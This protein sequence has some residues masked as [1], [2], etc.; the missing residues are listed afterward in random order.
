M[1]KDMRKYCLLI[2]VLLKSVVGLGQGTSSPKI[3]TDIPVVIPPSPTVASLMKFEEVPVSNYSGTPN[4][5]IPLFNLVGNH[6]L[7]FNMSLDYSPSSNKKEEIAGYTGLGWSLIAGGSISRTVRDIPDDAFVTPNNFH[8][9]KIGIYH[10]DEGLTM[11]R[12]NYYEIESL[13]TPN[14]V[15][16]LEDEGINRF[17]FETNEKH[18][19]DS[20]HDLYQF[21]FMGYTGR[22]IIKKKPNGT[23][24]IEKLDKNNLIINYNHTSKTFEI[25]DTKG[26]RYLFDI[27]EISSTHS[28][29]IAYKIDGSVNEDLIGDS[30]EFISAFQLSKIFYNQEL[31]AEFSYANFEENQ[32]TN[33]QTRNVP[34]NPSLHELVTAAHGDCNGQYSSYIPNGVLP[35]HIYNTNEVD[36]A[37]KKISKI[38]IINKALIDFETQTGEREDVNLKVSNSKPY[39]KEMTVRTWDSVTIVKKYKFDYL[40]THKMFLDK[41]TEETNPSQISKHEFRYNNL[42]EDYSNFDADYWGYYRYKDYNAECVTIENINRETDKIYC[43]KDA[44]KQIVYPTKG[45][46]IFEF[47]SNTYSYISDYEILDVNEEGYFDDFTNNPDNTTITNLDTIILSNSSSQNY[48]IGN[49]IYDL[50]IFTQDRVFIFNSNFTGVDDD[51]LGFLWLKGTKV[52]NPS[53]DPISIGIHTNGCPRELKLKEGYH[54]SIRFDWSIS[55]PHIVAA[56]ISIDEKTKNAETKQWL[57]GGG[58]RVKNIYYTDNDPEELAIQS[59][60]NNYSRKIGYDYNFFTGGSR[61]SGSLVFQKPKMHYQKKAMFNHLAGSNCHIFAIPSVDY[62][63]YTTTNNLSCIST[64]GSDVGYKNVAVSETGNGKTEFEYS[65]PI[66]YPEDM[67]S[68]SVAYPFAPTPNI[69]Y[70]RGL[71]TKTK[72][73]DSNSRILNE[74][75]NH[76]VFEDYDLI[77]GFT[78]FSLFPDC[79]YAG[80]FSN[81]DYYRDGVLDSDTFATD[82]MINGMQVIQGSIL[83]WN[84]RSCGEFVSDFVSYYPLKEAFGWVKLKNSF[85]VDYFYDPNNVQSYIEKSISYE[86]NSSNMQLSSEVLPTSNNGVNIENKY[87]YTIDSECDSEPQITALRNNNMVDTP[88]KIESF[89]NGSKVSEQKVIYND[90]GDSLLL[91]H[92]IQASKGLNSLENKIN[93]NAYNDYGHPLEVQQENGMIISYLWGY[94]QSQPIAKI[95][96]ATNAQVESA[97]GMGLEAVDESNLPTNLRSLL[98]NAMI[99]TYTY[100]PLVGVSTITDPR[101]MTTTYEYDS[102]GRLKWVKDYEGNIL[103]ENEYHYRTQN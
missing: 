38:K 18:K 74:N 43:K 86:Y 44:L 47:E 50:G 68:R 26:F 24:E 89:K 31:V 66:D 100:K 33:S 58:I 6:G 57:Y 65:S 60:P 52:S 16:D 8:T 32:T 2:I 78:T 29:S 97:L 102:F 56:T 14:Y 49:D 81:Y 30:T 41:I 17:F 71:L 90:W 12:N 28:M 99:T 46:A 34:V 76:Y 39:L 11:D 87:Y 42:D 82:E 91:P 48:P 103:S 62:E 67:N 85:S 59:Y 45:S 84:A 61:S 3:D 79:P 55:P 83:N 13:L 63:V 98:P 72:K 10:N 51:N 75:E 94:N 69:D 1:R 73:Y 36:I 92:I 19:F 54:Y 15:F 40:F 5:S 96:N 27:K 35:L 64:K 9:K 88:L 4:I 23:F 22:F 101:G 21:N 93:Y 7:A 53:E 77:T 37:T 80:M 95:E 25:K 20:K 70:K